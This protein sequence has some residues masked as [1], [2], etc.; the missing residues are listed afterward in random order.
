[1][2]W[3]F[4]RPKLFPSG[5]HIFPHNAHAGAFEGFFDQTIIFACF[6][7]RTELEVLAEKFLFLLSP[8]IQDM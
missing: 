2:K 6:A 3:G 7:T 4:F 8:F 1:V 5:K